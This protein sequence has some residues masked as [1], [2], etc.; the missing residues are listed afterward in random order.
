MEYKL[1][2]DGYSISWNTQWFG[3]TPGINATCPIAEYLSPHTEIWNALILLVLCTKVPS[4]G[5][6]KDLE[7]EKNPRPDW[8]P[9]QSLA[10]SACWFGTHGVLCFITGGPRP[11]LQINVYA[12][13]KG[14][15]FLGCI[16]GEESHVSRLILFVWCPFSPH[17][18]PRS[19]Q[20]QLLGF[21]NL[22]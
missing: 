13:N 21:K 3:G 6:G 11:R 15:H 22:F 4:E 10:P 2:A 9:P 14:H 12:G 5:H 1:P 18:M 17:A 7:R 8:N 19:K 20:S 16:S